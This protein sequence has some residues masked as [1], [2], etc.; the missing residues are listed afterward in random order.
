MDERSTA[1]TE[2]A[3]P[4]EHAAVTGRQERLELYATLVMALAAILTAWTAFEATKW[5]GVQAI[6][7]SE[8][9]AARIESSRASTRAGQQATIDVVTWTAWL[10]SLQVDVL[11]DPESRAELEARGY[12]PDPTTVSGFL[13]Q[14]FREEFRP[15]AAAWL[16]TRPS[17]NPDAPGTPFDMAEYQL[18]AEVLAEDELERAEQRSTDAREANQQSDDY[19]LTTV[20][21]ATVLF[22]AGLSTKLATER[23]RVLSLGIAVVIVLGAGGV[24]ATFPVEI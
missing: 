23:N 7:F 19:V 1:S 3:L 24:L 6:A 11:S 21:F 13:Y 15:A 4:P 12:V 17:A 18:A 22:F 10:E 14:R 9:S 16:E 8:A 5:S 20:A 2:D